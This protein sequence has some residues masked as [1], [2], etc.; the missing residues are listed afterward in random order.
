MLPAYR[1]SR[2]RAAPELRPP[3]PPRLLLGVI[4]LIDRRQLSEL[5]RRAPKAAGA[6]TMAQLE[7]EATECVQQL[8]MAFA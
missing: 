3:S 1:C 5:P 7:I 4:S 6:S 8:S 2:L